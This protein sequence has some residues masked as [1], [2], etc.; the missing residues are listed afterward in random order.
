MRLERMVL[1][2]DAVRVVQVQGDTGSRERWLGA[3][4]LGSTGQV[5]GDMG[6]IDNRMLVTFIAGA[7]NCT[8]KVE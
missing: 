4:R 1:Y 8:A 6:Y 5:G 2:D 3:S 7:I